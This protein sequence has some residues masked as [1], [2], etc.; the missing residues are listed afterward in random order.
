MTQGIILIDYENQAS[1]RHISW[2]TESGTR[3]QSRVMR[4]I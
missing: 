2:P 3:N 1:C 4:E